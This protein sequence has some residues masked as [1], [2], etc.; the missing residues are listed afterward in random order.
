[1]TSFDPR[2]PWAPRLLAAASAVLSTTMWWGFVWMNALGPGGESIPPAIV[3]AL[4]FPGVA[5]TGAIAAHRGAPLVTLLTGLIGLLPVGLYF[6][7]SPGVLKLIGVAPLMMFV[8]G[9]WLVRDL[10]RTDDDQS[11]S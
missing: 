10:R 5:W 11:I 8:A 4:L 7:V 9:V 2:P 1:M 3:A 6:L